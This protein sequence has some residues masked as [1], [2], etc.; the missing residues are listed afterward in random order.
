MPGIACAATT[1]VVGPTLRQE[2][3]VDHA[4]LTPPQVR[5]RL[6]TPSSTPTGTGSSPG[7]SSPISSGRKIGG[8]AAATGS[9]STGRQVRESLMMSAAVRLWGE[10]NPRFFEGTAVETAA[11]AVLAGRAT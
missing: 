4:H 7:R 8:E 3:P 6:F 1:T 5:A 9:V 11:A 10:V 2:V